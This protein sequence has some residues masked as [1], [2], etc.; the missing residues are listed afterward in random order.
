MLRRLFDGPDQGLNDNLQLLDGLRAPTRA[1]GR[2][3]LVAALCLALN[4]L[5]QTVTYDA[6]MAVTG[7]A[8]TL[9]LTDGFLPSLDPS[10]PLVEALEALGHRS[11]LLVSPTP[12]VVEDCVR[13]EITAGRPVLALGWGANPTAWSLL[14]GAQ[15]EDLLGYAY[16]GRRLDRHPPQVDLLLLLGDPAPGSPPDALALATLVRA[17][18]LLH[19]AQVQYAHW[20]G[21]LAAEEP[22]GPPLTRLERFLA[23]Q[24]LLSG[25]IEARDAAAAFLADTSELV[26]H[27][28]EPLEETAALAQRIVTRLEALQVAPEIIE[29]AGLP[30]DRDWLDQ[31]R[32]DLGDIRDLEAELIHALERVVIED[33]D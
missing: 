21:I 25:L 3:S 13:A 9:D 16:E 18:P 8:F 22:Y 2:S 12:A 30:E 14:A 27:A 28:T 33:V 26:Q 15:G 10:L 5:K 17:L 1:D 20:S 31:R 19:H 23:E 32:D 4:H 11:T 29:P 6:L 7:A 24:L